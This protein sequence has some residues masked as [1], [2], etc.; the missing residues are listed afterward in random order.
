MKVWLTTIALGLAVVQMVT[1]A[2][3]F[4]RFGDAPW[5]P[6]MHRWSG[7]LAVLITLPVVAHCLYAF[8][9]GYD[10]PRVLVALAGRMPVL[11]RVHRQDAGPAAAASACL[12]DPGPRG[13]VSAALVTVWTTS[14]L[15][16]FTA[17][18]FRL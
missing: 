6:V 1:A 15:W 13:P 9:F 2:G 8:G 14:S 7:R 12:G 10:S 18:G 4:G 16:F 17:Y 5:A 11:R 3:I